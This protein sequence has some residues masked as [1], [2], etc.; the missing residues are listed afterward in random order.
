MRTSVAGCGVLLG[1]LLASAV[2]ALAQATASVAAVQQVAEKQSGGAAWQ[3]AAVG[4]GLAGGDSFRTGKRSKADLKFAAGTLLRLGQLSR[5]TLRTGTSVDL[6]S[7]QVL[8]SKPPGGGG[9]AIINAG[10]AAAEIKGSVGIITRHA[11]G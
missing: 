6:Q 3:R 4:T 8:F 5:L 7:G 2:P 9:V 10:A 11:D 1:S